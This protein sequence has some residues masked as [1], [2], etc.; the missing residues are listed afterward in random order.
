MSSLIGH[1]Y[2]EIV[3]TI[4]E[5]A[6]RLDHLFSG[7]VSPPVVMLAERLCSVPPEGLDKAFFPFDWRGIE[8]SGY[9]NG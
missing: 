5:H 7:M 3:Q 6:A 8:R 9:Q 4:A 1:G 2:E